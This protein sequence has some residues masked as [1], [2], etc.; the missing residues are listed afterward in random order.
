MEYANI[1]RTKYSD[2]SAL[3]GSLGAWGKK[4]GLKT[5]RIGKYQ[6]KILRGLI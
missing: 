5:Q 1:I 4:Y 2:R 3:Y 6:F